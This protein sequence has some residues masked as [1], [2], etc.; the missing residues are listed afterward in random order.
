MRDGGAGVGCGRGASVVGP[1]PRSFPSRTL[2]KCVPAMLPAFCAPRYPSGL[3]LR[4]PGALARRRRNEER[5]ARRARR[6][7]RWFFGCPGPGSDLQLA[8]NHSEAQK[9]ETEK[10]HG[11]AA[12]GDA[13]ATAAEKGRMGK[14]AFCRIEIDFRSFGKSADVPNVGDLKFLGSGS[15]LE[16]NFYP[17]KC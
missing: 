12:V 1:P 13:Y 4:F 8:A 7:E 9:R 10:R 11:S 14:A 6:R 3:G 5:R 16:V 2:R 15:V 17:L